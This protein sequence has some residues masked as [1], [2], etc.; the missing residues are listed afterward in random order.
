MS[1]RRIGI[2]MGGIFHAI[3]GFGLRGGYPHWSEGVRTGYA[4]CFPFHELLFRTI[5][6]RSVKGFFKSDLMFLRVL[7]ILNW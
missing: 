2:A 1:V 7:L 5:K 4:V 3:L 6:N